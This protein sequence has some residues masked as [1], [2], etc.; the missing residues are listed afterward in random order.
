MARHHRRL[1]WKHLLRCFNRR[2][3][4]RLELLE[5]R[6]HF[7]FPAPSRAVLLEGRPVGLGDGVG[8]EQAVG[9]VRGHGPYGRA[10][11]PIDDDMR[12]VN[13]LD[14]SLRRRVSRLPRR[15]V[16]ARCG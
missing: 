14:T 6:P 13:A 5:P 12:D 11:A 4:R 1:V 2:P 8:V 16:T 15:L 7:D 10:D 3:T 9:L